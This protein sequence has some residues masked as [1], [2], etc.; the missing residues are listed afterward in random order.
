HRKRI[1]DRIL[2]PHFVGAILCCKDLLPSKV[3][4]YDITA[5]IKLEHVNDVTDYLIMNYGDIEYNFQVDYKH[6]TDEGIDFASKGLHIKASK[7]H[8]YIINSIK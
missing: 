4:L 7:H 3:Q 5:D 1:L 8:H 6:I 2:R